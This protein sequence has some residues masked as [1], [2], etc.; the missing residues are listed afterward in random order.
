ML[1]PPI[2]VDSGSGVLKAGVAGDKFPRICIPNL[3]A[4]P[5]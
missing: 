2:V 1:K 5:Q 4:R 3:V